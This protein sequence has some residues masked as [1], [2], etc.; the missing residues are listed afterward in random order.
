MDT[1]YERLTTLDA[2]FLELEDRTSH[3]HVGAV[4]LF[5]GPPPPYRDFLALIEARLEDVPRYRQRIMT[6]PLKQGRPVWIDETQ[7]DLEYHVRHTALPS[8]GGEEELKRLVG[9]LFSQA[10]D[11][12][13]PLWELRL[14]EGFGGDGSA[15][16]GRTPKAGASGDRFAIISK[17]H[18]CMLDGISGVDLATVLLDT[19][20]STEAP[21]APAEWK[22]R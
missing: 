9:R 20:P 2:M 13:K 12:D 8:P 6:V 5:E 1:W 4:A 7:F 17:T 21:A 16:D 14:V 18:H 19:E 22:P 11:R 10:L 3:M 15:G